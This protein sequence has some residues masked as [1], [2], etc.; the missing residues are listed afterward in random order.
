[1][2]NE[3]I[4]EQ[5]IDGY[6]TE[7]ALFATTEINGKRN[8][9]FDGEGVWRWRAQSYLENNS[10]EEFDDFIGKTIQYLASNKRRSRLEVSNETFYYNN[11]SIKI[12]AQYFDKNFVF[13]SRASLLISVTNTETKAKKEFPLLLKSNFYEVDLNNLEAGNYTYKV[14]VNGEAVSRSGKFTILNFNVEQQFLNADVTKLSRVATNTN[15]KAYFISESEQ[16]ISNLIE[17]NTFQKIQK[18][19]QKT[20]PLIDWK[21][22][23]GLIV[24]SLSIEW[25][26][27][28]YNGLI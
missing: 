5:S 19:Q 3:F 24:L 22:L 17:D 18:S 1:M 9:I 28:K 23:L 20:V 6:T 14:S 11:K 21:Y 2:P 12:S 10:F 16:L 4:L 13:D 27:R 25:F 8:A 26:L 7:S 15:G